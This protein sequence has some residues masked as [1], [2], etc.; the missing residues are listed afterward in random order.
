[1][2]MR[3]IERVSG[4]V[5]A[6]LSLLTLVYLI[7]YKV[8]PGFGTGVSPRFFPYLCAGAIFLLSLVLVVRPPSSPDAPLEATLESRPLR[9]LGLT[10]LMIAVCLWLTER[11][12]YLAGGAL[13][14][15]GV[16]FL[17]GERRVLPIAGISIGWSVFLWVLF[18]KVLSTP[19][20]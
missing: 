7:P 4:L 10:L 8:D 20:P 5:M 16:M 13:L 9:K 12:G 19:L 3:L 2:S 14:V 6:A 15:A 17:M 18:E 1:M 11:F